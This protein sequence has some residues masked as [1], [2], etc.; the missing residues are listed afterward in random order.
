MLIESVKV[1]EATCSNDYSLGE[2]VEEDQE[3]RGAEEG[4]VAIAPGQAQ[5]VSVSALAAATPLHT[6]PGSPVIR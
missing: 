4:W 1:Q 3:E 5:R 6:R 2:A